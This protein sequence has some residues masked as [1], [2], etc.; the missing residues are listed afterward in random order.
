[1]R[2]IHHNFT[3]DA[4]CQQRPNKRYEPNNWKIHNAR[5]EGK[6]GTVHIVL[7]DLELPRSVAATRFV[8]HA[9]SS[10][11]DAIRSLRLVTQSAQFASAASRNSC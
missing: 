2:T 11:C 8:F 10:I 1:M 9:Y 3:P 5:K 7:A 6:S 4:I